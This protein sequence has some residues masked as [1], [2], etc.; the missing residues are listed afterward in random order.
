MSSVFLLISVLYHLKS[1]TFQNNYKI[2]Y[3]NKVLSKNLNLVIDIEKEKKRFEKISLEKNL[4]LTKNYSK[5]KIL[6][7]GDSMSTN[8]IDAINQNKNLYNKK[9]E[10]NNLILDEDCFK[11]L[12]SNKYLNKQCKN[13]VEKFLNDLSINNY[14]S[15]FILLQ[16][17]KKSKIF[18]HFMSSK[19][20][21]I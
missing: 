11:F 5:Q 3:Q 13:F 21:E 16:W 19:D 8:W 17:T 7:L 15:I 4:S 14:D 18:L 12:K 10:F 20:I 1:I 6:I 2:E 9:Y